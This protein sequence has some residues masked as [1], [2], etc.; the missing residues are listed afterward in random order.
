MGEKKKIKW[1]GMAK[2]L[3]KQYKRKIPL[4]DTQAQLGRKGKKNIMPLIH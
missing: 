3:T 2:H 1:P 4:E